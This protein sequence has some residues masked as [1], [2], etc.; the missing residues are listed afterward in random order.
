MWSLKSTT[1]AANSMY[2]CYEVSNQFRDVDVTRVALLVKQGSSRSI[3][4]FVL[5]Y[6]LDGVIP[7]KLFK[8]RPLETLIGKRLVKLSASVASMLKE[9]SSA[10]TYCCSV[11]SL[12]TL[13]AL[14]MPLL[15]KLKCCFTSTETVGLLGTGNPGRPPRLSH[16][17]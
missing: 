7:A 8:S 9:V 14:V 13:P 16:S 12:Q 10:V 2:C 17:S 11:S 4:E 1:I 6:F 15:L 3:G 5:C